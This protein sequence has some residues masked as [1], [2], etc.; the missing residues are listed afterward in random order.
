MALVLGIAVG[1]ILGLTGAGGS[2]LAVPLLMAG[3]GWSITQAAPVALLAV[4]SASAFGTYI[5][6]RKS[7]VRY[8]AALLMSAAGVLLAPLGIVSAQHLP[9]PIL[10]LIFSAVLVIVALRM[11]YRS[12]AAPM[13]AGIVR[14]TVAGDG[15]R[16]SGPIC[17]LKENGRILW[18]RACF[19]LMLAIGAV[20]GFLSGLIGVGGGFVIVPSLR[21]GSALSMH[22]A[23]ATSLMVIALTSTGTVV[24]TIAQGQAIPWLIALPFVSGALL[25]MFGGGK[26]APFIAGP[27][28]QRAFAGLMLVIAVR[29]SGHALGWF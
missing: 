6:W 13:E 27:S 4:A 9:A 17:R 19:V 7:Y 16:A 21:A 3:L 22:S 12:I 29:L 28:L 10:A 2:I 8:R 20:T 24:T 23:V 11:G 26:I 14:A 25:G 18:T 5:A 1:L 15:A